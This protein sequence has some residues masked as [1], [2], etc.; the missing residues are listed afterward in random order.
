MA[1]TEKTE[2]DKCEVLPDGTIQA[3]TALI[4]ERDD[5]EVSR[6][7]INR[8]VYHPGDDVSNA[9]DM[10]KKIAEVE[11]TDAAKAAYANHLVA[12]EEKRLAMSGG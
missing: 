10:V 7:Y 2:V 12:T 9:T 3:R 6:K 11:H 1:L 8:Q 4:I 5:V